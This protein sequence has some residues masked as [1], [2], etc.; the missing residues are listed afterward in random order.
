[1]KTKVFFSLTDDICFKYIFGKEEILKDFLN[2]FFSYLNENKKVMKIE[3]TTN[4]E[5]IGRNRKNKIFYGDI[6]AFLNT[7][8]IVSLEIYNYFQEKEFN[9]SVSYLTRIYSG[10]LKPGESYIDAKKVISINLMQGSFNRNHHLMDD[11]CFINKRTLKKLEN[12]PLELFL[13]HIDLV[14]D[15]V[16]NDDEKRFIKWLKLIKAKDMVEMSKIAKGD[17][18]ME[19]AVKF[20]RS[21]VNDE[22][23]LDI[24]D[25]INDVKYYAKEEGHAEGL[26]EGHVKGIAENKKET[27]KKMLEDGLDINQIAKYTGL[28]LSEINSF[29]D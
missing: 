20:M 12:N 5:M 13:I 10:Q 8:E 2:S 14:N 15:N 23:V 16:Y 3:I 6:L 21:F 25:K 29:K 17:K 7:Q 26:A 18:N 1:M 24:Y 28:S 27:A 11:Y 9:K 4:K 19:Q 22:E